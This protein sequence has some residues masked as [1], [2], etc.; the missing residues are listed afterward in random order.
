MGQVGKG[1][2]FVED[3]SLWR[4]LLA[5]GAERIRRALPCRAESSREVQRLVVPSC[6]SLNA[7]PL[8]LDLTASPPLKTRRAL[9]HAFAAYAVLCI[10]QTNMLIGRL[11]VDKLAR[12]VRLGARERGASEPT[13]SR[14]FDVQTP[15]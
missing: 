6:H 1:R 12:A 10:P 2:V 5:A 4:A 11:C 7:T 3:H 15:T 9:P 8:H 14:A 13:F